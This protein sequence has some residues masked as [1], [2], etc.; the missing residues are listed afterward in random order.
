MVAAG[1]AVTGV[2]VVVFKPAAGDQTYVLAPLAV[3]L[4]EPPLQ[5]AGDTGA[6]ATMGNALTITVTVTNCVLVQPFTSV[7]TT[8]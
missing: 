5:T 2:P 7:P 4:M 3:K 6:L 1:V 8:V